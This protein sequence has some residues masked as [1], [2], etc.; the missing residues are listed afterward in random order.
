[1]LLYQH[2]IFNY[3]LV[4]GEKKLQL[5]CSL[6][7]LVHVYSL[8]L[9]DCL[10]CLRIE[11]GPGVFQSSV[12]MFSFRRLFRLLAKSIR[13]MDYYVKNTK[14][15]Q[16]KSEQTKTTITMSQGNL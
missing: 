12:K 14:S 5:Q 3:L 2:N 4:K 7:R 8:P 15:R 10:R 6:M 1:M 9:D 16:K 13:G 11:R